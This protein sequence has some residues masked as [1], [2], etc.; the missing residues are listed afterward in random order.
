MKKV[1]F[2]AAC[3]MAV[4]PMKA[5]T[6]IGDVTVNVDSR[7]LTI[8]VSANTPELNGLAQLAFAS[9]GRY[10]VV[11]GTAQFEVKFTQVSATQ[12]K[13]DVTK[14]G[15]PFF[16]TTATGTSPRNALLKAAD[17]V[18]EKTN[19]QGLK[20]WFA[21]KVAFISERTGKKEVYV[22][23]LFFGEA[24]QV[25]HDNA[26]ALSPR[27]TPDGRH[28]VYTSF[29]KSGFPDIFLI[30]TA[31]YQRNSFVSFK[32]TNSGARFSPNGAQ[33]AMIL[34]GE[35]NPDL[36]VTNSSG[37]L[38]HRITRTDAVE[39][40]PCWS[41]DGSRIVYTSDAA[42]GPQ[43]YVIPASGGAP[44]RLP[45]G[46]SG[47]CAEPDWSKG[48]PNKI[49]FTLR[50]GKGYQIGVYDMTT[51][52]A[53]QVSKAPYDGIEPSWLADGRHLVYTA[54]TPGDSR[55]CILDTETGNTK[56]VSPTTLGQVMQVSVSGP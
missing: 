24:K 55:I 50:I 19:M 18:V 14:G 44:S 49:A 8:K 1:L 6:K 39:A 48:N 54:R 7:V 31:T 20:G 38:P 41:P 37:H 12:V 26:S 28:I 30:D 3:L 46:I 45:T 22:G 52:T 43:L 25:T 32:G 33:V 17:A 21:S 51:R 15:S 34:S 36:Y 29:Y 53:A 23:D 47:Y 35:G 11:P 27:W 5:V 42:G 40:S 16:S 4:A 2:L 10:K 13:A 9:H 56:V